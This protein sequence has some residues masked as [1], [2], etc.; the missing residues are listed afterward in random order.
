MKYIKFPP[1]DILKEELEKNNSN[2]KRSRFITAMLRR[3]ILI[4]DTIFV[5]YCYML[6]CHPKKVLW[7]N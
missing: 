6:L 2:K 3:E 4:Q 7:W 5:T 1:T